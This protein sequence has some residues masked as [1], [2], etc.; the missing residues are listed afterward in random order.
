MSYRGDDGITPTVSAEDQ[1]DRPFSRQRKAELMP[2]SGALYTSTWDLYRGSGPAWVLEFSTDN[3]GNIVDSTLNGVPING[4]LDAS[5]NLSFNDAQFPGEIFRVTF[6]TGM[7]FPVDDWEPDQTFMAGTFQETEVT[8][9]G[10][11]GGQQPPPGNASLA[12][13]ASAGAAT[14]TIAA[15]VDVAVDAPALGFGS[16]PPS[17]QVTTLRGPWYAILR[18]LDM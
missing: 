4:T 12:D 18:F 14:A 15:P 16:G 11:V 7:V 1:F 13:T 3:Y 8:V 9:T 5:L 2:S 10:G 6:Y 17:V